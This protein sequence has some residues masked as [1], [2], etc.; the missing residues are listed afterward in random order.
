MIFNDDVEAAH[1]ARFEFG[2]S[3][4]Y[5]DKDSLFYEV[6]QRRSLE[7][8]EHNRLMFT[9]NEALV[10]APGDGTLVLVG[11][12]RDIKRHRQRYE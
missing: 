7:L 8:R 10:I 6:R 3:P 11:D 12:E 5:L 1:E 2:F 4:G 9:E